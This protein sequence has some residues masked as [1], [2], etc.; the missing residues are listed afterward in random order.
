MLKS[1]TLCVSGH[2]PVFDRGEKSVNEELVISRMKGDYL[3]SRY[4]KVDM[5]TIN[6]FNEKDDFNTA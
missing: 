4:E 6:S 5:T 1:D 3:T 2:D